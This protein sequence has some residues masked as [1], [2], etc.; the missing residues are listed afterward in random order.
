MPLFA[1]Y[2]A[3]A[4]AS[5][6][7]EMFKK[8]GCTGMIVNSD[9]C[10]VSVFGYVS[11]YEKVKYED[12][13]AREHRSL[14]FESVLNR[15]LFDSWKLDMWSNNSVQADRIRCEILSFRHGLA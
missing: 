1:K 15:G 4:W 5:E 10:T 2:E 14:I 9:E 11:H 13:W 6:T 8:A 3:T 7:K 12:E